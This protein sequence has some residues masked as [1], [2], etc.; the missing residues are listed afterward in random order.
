MIKIYISSL[1]NYLQEESHETEA[2]MN[3]VDFVST[4]TQ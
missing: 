1:K 4:A 3:V 2:K